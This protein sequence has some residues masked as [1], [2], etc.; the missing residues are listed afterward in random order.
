MD[1]ELPIT[2]SEL[3]DI[4]GVKEY[5][6]REKK[7]FVELCRKRKLSQSQTHIALN[8]WLK[9]QGQSQVHLSYV[10]RNW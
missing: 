6:R 5:Y 2:D 9:S 1:L 4:L 7:R 8:I 3:I 10:K